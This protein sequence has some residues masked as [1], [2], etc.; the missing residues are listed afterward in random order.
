MT[1]KQIHYFLKYICPKL[2][3]YLMGVISIDMLKN[4]KKLKKCHFIVFNESV[5]KS[6][7]MPVLEL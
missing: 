4:V 2:Y 3:P 7:G 5:K 6:P 1:G